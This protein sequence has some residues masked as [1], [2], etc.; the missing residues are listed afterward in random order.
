VVVAPF[1]TDRACHT[2]TMGTGIFLEEVDNKLVEMTVEHYELEDVLQTLLI[3]HPDLLPGDQINQLSPRKWVLVAREQPLRSEQGGSNRWNIDHVFLDQDGILT[4]VEV[5]RSSDSRIRRGVVG[6]MLDYAA[7]VA[8]Y[9]PAD[10]IRQCFEARCAKEGL[11]PHRILNEKFGA[12]TDVETYWQSVESN[13]LASQIRILFVADVIPTELQRIIEFLNEQMQ[14]V[15]VLGVSIRRFQSPGNQHAYV[16]RVV[17]QTAVAQQMKH[18]RKSG[19]Q[20]DEATFFKELSLQ[21]DPKE[22]EVGNRIYEWMT[23]NLPKPRWGEG[24]DKGSFLPHLEL[25]EVTYQPV[26]IWT[27]GF[28]ELQFETLWLEPPFDSVELQ[29]E[30]RE[31]FSAVPGFEVRAFKMQRPWAW[32]SDLEQEEAMEQFLK[33]LD[34]L[35]GRLKEYVNHS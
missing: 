25:G 33:E 17:G 30:A 6:Q 1:A 3:E 21:C 32:F 22:L 11:D 7:S 29:I 15:E 28:V 23:E 8:V 18:R 4:L 27:P 5:K 12:E 13:L 20:W 9:W 19:R 2:L 10:E 35:V 31:R 26:A 34:W 24:N 16:A 14:A